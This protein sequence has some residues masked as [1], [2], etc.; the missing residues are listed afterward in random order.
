MSSSFDRNFYFST[1]SSSDDSSYES[2][3]SYDSQE[4]KV[5]P[6]ESILK[7][8]SDC[9]ENSLHD[10]SSDSS[11][12][13][14]ESPRIRFETRFIQG[15]IGPIGPIGPTGLTGPIGPIGPTGE[16]GLTGPIG[17]IGP[18]GP[19]GPT[20]AE[21][22][23]TFLNSYSFLT[24]GDTQDLKPGEEVFFSL[25]SCVLDSITRSSASGVC[26]SEAGSYFVFYQLT[27]VGAGNLVICLNGIEQL[28]TIV[29]KDKCC[30]H[31]VCGTVVSTD[32]K[33]TILTVR[34]P[35]RANSTLRLTANDGGPLGISNHIV[36]IRLS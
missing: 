15:P 26:V 22:K 32:E 36:V 13:S 16:T 29:A 21:S 31:L 1:S 2:D 19:T 3:S 34:N 10:S 4:E 20:G 18:I 33:D 6:I 30:G 7:Q 5:I 27:A 14:T 11:S 23:K 25:N 28:H 35:V 8:Q 24:H 17:P 12:S 9:K